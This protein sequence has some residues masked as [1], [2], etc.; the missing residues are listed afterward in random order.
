MTIYQDLHLLAEDKRIEL[1][2]HYVSAHHKAI[3][4]LVDD[5]PAKVARYIRKLLDRSPRL[6][7]EQGAGPVAGVV[8]LRV[9]IRAGGDHA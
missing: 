9:S 8:A 5:E 1:I 7:V 2:E 6:M 3:T 4:V